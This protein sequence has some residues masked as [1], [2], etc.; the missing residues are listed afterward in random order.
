VTKIEISYEPA[1]KWRYAFAARDGSYYLQHGFATAKDALHYGKDAMQVKNLG[2]SHY[3]YSERLSGWFVHYTRES[4]WG[5]SFH[6]VHDDGGEQIH[7][8]FWTL[9]AAKRAARELL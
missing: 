5:W 6:A 3:D 2:S 4:L 9:R 8:G 7:C 1:T